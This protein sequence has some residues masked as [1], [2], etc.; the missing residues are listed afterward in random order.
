MPQGIYTNAFSIG[1]NEFLNESPIQGVSPAGIWSAGS[2]VPSD[3]GEV[4]IT[5]KAAMGTEAFRHWFVPGAAVPVSYSQ[6]LTVAQGST[7]WPIAFYGPSELPDLRERIRD[8]IEILIDRLPHINPPGDPATVDIG[9]G[10]DRLKDKLSR[11]LSKGDD[12]GV[13]LK[14]PE[15]VDRGRLK[16][17]LAEVDAEIG[18]LEILKSNISD[19]LEKHK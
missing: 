12:L 7:I 13:M 10:L 18:R 6:E 3:S 9:R 11:G 2:F 8:L 5:A 17:G 14:N 19:A 16:Q 4:R 15:K 1:N